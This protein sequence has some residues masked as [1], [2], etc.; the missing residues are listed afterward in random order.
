MF[1]EISKLYFMVPTAPERKISCTIPVPFQYLFTN[2][3]VPI[4]NLIIGHLRAICI[5]TVPNWWKLKSKDPL[6]L[7]VRDENCSE[8]MLAPNVLGTWFT[9]WG[10]G[11][12]F[13]QLVVSSRHVNI[14]QYFLYLLPCFGIFPGFYANLLSFLYL[15]RPWKDFRNFLYLSCTSWICGNHVNSTT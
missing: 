3:P 9:I 12:R 2:F 4:Y 1:N 8:K 6:G 13:V 10:L 14:D 7:G 11:L 5:H 15:S